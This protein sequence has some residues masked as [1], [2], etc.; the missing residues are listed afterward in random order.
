MNNMEILGKVENFII[1]I[2][3]YIEN[4]YKI[5]SLYSN[6]ES[7]IVNVIKDEKEEILSFDLEG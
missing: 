4:G 6:N 3:W 1:G 7:V 2:R 5:I